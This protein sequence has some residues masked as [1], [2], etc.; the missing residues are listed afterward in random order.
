MKKIKSS[1]DKKLMTTFLLKMIFLSAAFILILSALVSFI[2]YKLD[3]DSALLNYFSV[4]AA[5]ISAAFTAFFCARPFKNN[6]FLIGVVSTFP[7]L[8]FSIINLIVN[9]NNVGVFFIKLF[10][11]IVISGLSGAY[12]VKKSKKIRVKK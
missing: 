12:S 4:G 9:A 11:C 5:A 3:L 1:L 8:I 10:V 6:G 7:L 2:V